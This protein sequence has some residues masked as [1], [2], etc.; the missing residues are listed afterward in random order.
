MNDLPVINNLP[1]KFRGW[2]LLLIAAFPY[3]TR[4]FYAIATGGGIVGIFRAVLFGTNT[5]PKSDAP[6][7]NKLGLLLALGAASLIF[8]G[9]AN[10]NQSAFKTEYA[11]AA[12]CDA[13]MRGYAAYWKTAI[14]APERY[15]RTLAGLNQERQTLENYSMKIGGTIEL[16]EK[17]RVAYA[18][19]SAVKPQLQSALL[20]LSANAAGIV[21][22]ATTFL[23]TTNNQ[24][25]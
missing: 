15:N 3:L 13:A 18:T 23:N 16:T 9:C 12:S 25:Y 11:A 20:S 2:A 21:A 6:G 5:P 4:G 7:G 24:T 10:V 17:L 8:T 14:V 1:E 22:T 19:N